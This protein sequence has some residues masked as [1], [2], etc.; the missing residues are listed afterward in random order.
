LSARRPI[1]PARQ[2]RS[3]ALAHVP[4]DIE[5]QLAAI[6][7]IR[8]GRGPEVLLVHGGASPTTTWSTLTPM[9]SRWTL[10][11]AHRRGFPPSPPPPGGREDFEVDAADLAPLLGG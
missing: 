5:A 4:T 10:A 1:P 6:A 7:V 2:S 8:E 9:S 11:F 3:T